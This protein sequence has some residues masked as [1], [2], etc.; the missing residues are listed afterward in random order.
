MTSSAGTLPRQQLLGIARLWG[1]AWLFCDYSLGSRR[2]TQ[3]LRVKDLLVPLCAACWMITKE[4]CQW[5]PGV[6]S[7]SLPASLELVGTPNRPRRWKGQSACMSWQW[8]ERRGEGRTGDQPL[9][10][11]PIH[12]SLL[13]LLV[14]SQWNIKGDS[15]LTKHYGDKAS[16]RCNLF[17]TEMIKFLEWKSTWLLTDTIMRICW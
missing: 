15:T 14:S 1:V 8:A 6:Y 5:E 3:I 13:T 7:Y 11:P 9:E 17:Y 4:T 2:G 10:N 16:K 12:A